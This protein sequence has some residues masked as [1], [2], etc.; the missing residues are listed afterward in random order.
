MNKTKP[1]CRHGIN[2]DLRCKRCE[3]SRLHINTLTGKLTMLK[4]KH[5]VKAETVG[6]LEEALA[7]FDRD[8]PLECFN[9]KHVVIAACHDYDT[10]KTVCVSLDNA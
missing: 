5:G 1:Y 3:S 10:D 6:E 9:A 7:N 4:I 2:T 8:L